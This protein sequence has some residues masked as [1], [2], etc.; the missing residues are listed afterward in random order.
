MVNK[1][2]HDA[3]VTITEADIINDLAYPLV[4]ELAYTYG[5]QVIHA[6][7]TNGNRAKLYL[8]REDG[9]CVGYVKYNSEDA[10]AFRSVVATKERGGRSMDDRHTW[11]SSKLASLMRIIKKENLIPYRDWETDRKSTRLNSSH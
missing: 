1:L 7:E 4:R 10:Y 2:V 9:I 6:T 8:A 3:A 11:H 5:T